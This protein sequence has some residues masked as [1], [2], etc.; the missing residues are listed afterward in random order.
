LRLC[1]IAPAEEDT[2]PNLRSGRLDNISREDCSQSKKYVPANSAAK[3]AAK[4]GEDQV[5]SASVPIKSV[6][7]SAGKA[8]KGKLLS[9]GSTGKATV[10]ERIAKGSVVTAAAD[11]K[12][13]FGHTFVQRE[14]EGYASYHFVSKTE[15]FI[16]YAS[17]PKDWRLDGGTCFP[18]KKYFADISYDAATRTMTCLVD[19]SPDTKRGEQRWQYEMV[20]NEIFTRIAGGKIRMFPPRAAEPTTIA[21]FGK[22]MEYRQ[23]KEIE[24]AIVNEQI[25]RAMLVEDASK[26]SF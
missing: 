23:M 5:S 16:S 3:P 15:C 17:V 9:A 8:T 2:Q 22:Q 11:S 13:P 25:R 26:E 20:F 1:C 14:G 4:S 6:V 24:D 18:K 10:D 21:S 19:W 7:R 12:T